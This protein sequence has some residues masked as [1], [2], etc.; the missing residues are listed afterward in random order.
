LEH[1]GDLKTGGGR[2]GLSSRR[3]SSWYQTG[4]HN[5][6]TGTGAASTEIL[7]KNRNLTKSIRVA[8]GGKGVVV[9]GYPTCK[10]ES[11]QWRSIL[12]HLTHDVMPALIDRR[13]RR[14]CQEVNQ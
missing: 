10:K 14:T 5:R 4:N 8:E 11:T 7:P 1:D 2:Q 9:A 3:R 13:D 12:D 6:G